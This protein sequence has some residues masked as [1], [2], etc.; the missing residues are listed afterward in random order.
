M[1][2]KNLLN[3]D[4]YG[5][6]VPTITSDRGNVLE[7]RK[8]PFD[9]GYKIMHCNSYSWKDAQITDTNGI[10]FMYSPKAPTFK[11]KIHAVRFMMEKAEFLA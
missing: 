8:M 6:S 10:L 11:S 9:K 5:N 7:V 1:K 2:K 4:Y 3:R